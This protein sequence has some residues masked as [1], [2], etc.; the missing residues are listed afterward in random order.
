MGASLAELCTAALTRN[1]AAHALEFEGRWYAWGEL[2]RIADKVSALLDASGAGPDDPVVFI[3]RNRPS[4]IAA[5]FALMARGR[6]IR[7]IYAFQSPAGIARDIARLASAVVVAGAGEFSEEVLAV[8]GAQGLAGICLDEAD[9]QAVPGHGRVQ[10]KSAGSA[11][12][13]PCIEILTS[14]T[15]GPPKQFP[16]S[17]EMIATHLVGPALA[18]GGGMNWQEEPPAI[19]YFPLGNISGI[20]STLPALIRGQ[21]AVLLDRFSLEAWLD[22]VRRH[23]PAATGI[24][25][26]LMRALLEARIPAEDL[27]SIKAMGLGAAPLDPALQRAFEERYGIPILLSYGATEFGGPVAAMTADLH[28]RFGRQKLGSVGRALPGARLRVIDADTGRI[29]PPGERGL[30]EVVSPRIG[31]E[32]LRTSDLAFLDEDGFLFLCGRADGAIVRGGFKILPETIE[33]ALQLHPEVTEAAVVGVP[34]PR[35]GEVP[36]AVVVMKEKRDGADAALLESFL[37]RQLA[38]T[39]IPVHWRFTD[40]LPRNASCKLDRAALRMLFARTAPD[41]SRDMSEEGLASMR[42]TGDK[43]QC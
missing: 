34:D 21:R 27:A 41:R 24:P 36:G 39:H 1:P 30:L 38:A 33:Q 29:L 42:I 37:R 5:L 18:A 22:Y 11:A 16:V 12:G 43:Q 20:Y 26:S 15:T 9:V 3:P 17:H 13:E 28:A 35:L 6:S 4:A 40:A 14:G 10:R 19:L 32:W 23:R 7:M 2:R 25:P 31:P 8:I